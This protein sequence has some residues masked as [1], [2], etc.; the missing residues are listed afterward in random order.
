MV[1]LA[2]LFMKI[3]FYRVQVMLKILSYYITELSR[4]EEAII[5]MTLQLRLYCHSAVII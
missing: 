5:L 2:F 3:T 1:E 4:K